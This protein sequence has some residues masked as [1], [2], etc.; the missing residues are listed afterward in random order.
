MADKT[1]ANI[2]FEKQLWDAACVLWG[3]IPAA[4]YRKV[5]IGLIF[6]RYISAAFDKRYQ[7]LVDEG[8]GFEDDRDAYTMENVFFGRRRHGGALLPQPLTR[9]RSARS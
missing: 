2:G 5:I 1:N 6:L 4:E 7:E 9:R 3:H 8:D